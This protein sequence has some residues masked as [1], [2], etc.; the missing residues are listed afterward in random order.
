MVKI[1]KESYVSKRERDDLSLDV[2]E[3]VCKKLDGQQWKRIRGPL[4]AKEM[5]DCTVYVRE[6]VVMH[7]AYAEVSISL[8]KLRKAVLK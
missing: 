1:R 5:F 4:S 2:A 7:P 8:K 3:L 6:L